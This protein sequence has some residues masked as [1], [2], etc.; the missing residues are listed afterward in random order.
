MAWFFVGGETTGQCGAVITPLVE[1]A[2]RRGHIPEAYL[3]EGLQRLA[4]MT[5]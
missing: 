2:L 1:R 4:T 3:A 5:K